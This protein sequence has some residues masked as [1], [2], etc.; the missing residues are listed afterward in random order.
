MDSVTDERDQRRAHLRG[1][2]FGNRIHQDEENQSGQ[3]K[4]EGTDW[5]RVV[6][7]CLAQYD[8]SFVF[9]ALIR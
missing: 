1:E 3:E 8:P 4:S 2:R 5:T 6:N 7:R 9:G